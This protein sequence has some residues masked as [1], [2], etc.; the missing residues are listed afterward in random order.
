MAVQ[1]ALEE[2]LAA[3]V[4]YREDA[5]SEANSHVG[6][7]ESRYDTFK[8]D[9]QYLAAGHERAI[10]RLREQ[11][12]EL[13]AIQQSKAPQWPKA[14]ALVALR[15]VNGTE[16]GWAVLAADVD[17]RFA[18]EDRD[19]RQWRVMHPD[20]KPGAALLAPFESAAIEEALAAGSRRDALAG[21]FDALR[22]AL[23]RAGVAEADI[24]TGVRPAR[25]CSAVPPASG[26]AGLGSGI[27]EEAPQGPRGPPLA[28]GPV[29]RRPQRG[30]AGRFSSRRSPS[31]SPRLRV[32]ASRS[33]G[34]PS[35]APPSPGGSRYSTRRSRGQSRRALNLLTARAGTGS[36]ATF[37][38]T[39]TR[40]LCLTRP[41]DR[42]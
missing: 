39:S 25:L 28:R 9:A 13:R 27:L 17:P 4:R 36:W 22:D 8:E 35:R 3:A 23:E 34:C 37:W 15:D 31:A 1:T 24:L 2:R 12:G 41:S 5:Q 38:T 30:A 6:A 19:G 11:L 7:M 21:A 16:V 10:A 32:P 26:S 18:F 33:F 29:E 20:S 14:G 42:R 40:A